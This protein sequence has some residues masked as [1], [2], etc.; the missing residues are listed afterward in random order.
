MSAATPP[1]GGERLSPEVLSQLARK[2]R[3]LAELRRARAAGEAIPAKEVFRALAGE[4]PGA[5][6]E[7]DNLPFDEIER[8]HDALA[9]ALA[10]GAE[11]RWMAWIHGYHT[12]MR[13]ALYVK[14]RVARRQ[15]LSGSEA[16]ALAERAA[17]HAGVVVD[18]AFVIAVKTPPDGRLNR[19]VLGRLAAQS[20]ASTAEIRETIFP[21]RPAQGG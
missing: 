21:R 18:A 5:L 1:D 11:E 9:R 16:A 20:G 12:L 2:Y 3:A 8:R 4:F 19:L 13:A 7:L 10:G 15:E 6:N 17:K 14:I